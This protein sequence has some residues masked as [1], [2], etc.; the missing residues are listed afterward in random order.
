MSVTNTT[1]LGRNTNV[2]LEL[3]AVAFTES[4]N[5][6]V[7]VTDATVVSSGIP[8][9]ITFIS[10]EIPAVLSIVTVASLLVVSQVAS[11]YQDILAATVLPFTSFTLRSRRTAVSSSITASAESKLRLISSKYKPSDLLI[12]SFKVDPKNAQFNT[13]PSNVQ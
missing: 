11:L 2:V 3:V 7:F 12:S 9:P 5:V 10:A 13:S 8:V 4:S 6:V 1:L